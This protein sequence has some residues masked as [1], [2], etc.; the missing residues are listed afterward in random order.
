M[1]CNTAVVRRETQSRTVDE[2]L[3]FPFLCEIFIRQVV[4][5]TN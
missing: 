2:A 4:N 3:A 5:I 1:D